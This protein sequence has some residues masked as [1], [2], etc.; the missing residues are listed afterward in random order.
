VRSFFRSVEDVGAGLSQHLFGHSSQKYL[1]QQGRFP[2]PAHDY[3]VALPFPFLS[4]RLEGGERLRGEVHRNEHVPVRTGR[5][6]LST[7]TGRRLPAAILPAVEP[8]TMRGKALVPC[9]APVSRATR[10]ARLAA[11]PAPGEKSVPASIRR[12]SFIRQPP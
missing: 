7:R 10:A 3:Q 1:F 11:S 8:T 9:A 4:C 12:N 2:V 6:L 5:A